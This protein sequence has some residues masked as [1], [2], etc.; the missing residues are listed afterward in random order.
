MFFDLFE[1][2]NVNLK[3]FEPV[4]VSVI[5]IDVGYLCIL[6]IAS[7]ASF[8]EMNSML[9]LLLKSHPNLCS[10]LNETQHLAVNRECH[11]EW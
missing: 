4:G 3:S 9:H 8:S 7:S 1:L 11:N 10:V 5:T 2:V 6:N